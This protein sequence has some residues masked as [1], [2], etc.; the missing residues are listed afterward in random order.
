MSSLEYFFFRRCQMRLI[1]QAKLHNCQLSF[2][3]LKVLFEGR[4]ENWQT[5]RR[6]CIIMWSWIT[7]WLHNFG[8]NFNCQGNRD[9]E[10]LAWQ[11]TWAFVKMIVLFFNSK[12]ISISYIILLF[13]FNVIFFEKFK[14]SN[15][16]FIFLWFLPK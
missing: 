1:A 16:F 9:R 13:N 3:V 10:D 2:L 7:A 12:R 14:F 11:K 8:V 6:F 15:L 4:K 5:R